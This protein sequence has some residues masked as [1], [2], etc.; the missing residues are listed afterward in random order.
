MFWI[1]QLLGWGGLGATQILIKST[2]I[3]DV[4]LYYVGFEGLMITVSGILFSSIM[5]QVFVKKV[6]LE[7]FSFSSLAW[8]LV[9]ILLAG[10]S[11]VGFQYVLASNVYEYIHQ[12]EIRYSAVANIINTFIMLILW[13]ILYFSIKAMLKSQKEKVERLRLQS[14]LKESQLNTLKGQIN[15]HFMFNSLNNIRGLMLEDVTKSREMIT[16]LS[17][18]LRYS[19]NSGKI[20]M[21]AVKEELVTVRNYIELS[22]IQLEDRLRYKEDIETGVQDIQIPPMLIQML[23]ENAI[24]HGISNQVSGGEVVLKLDI[25]DSILNIVVSNNGKLRNNS[26]STKI[27]IVNMRERLRLLYGSRASLE[28]KEV[29][30]NVIAK[31]K[32]PID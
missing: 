7:D 10:L 9:T 8:V 26:D 11:L 12:K 22:K 28:L 24:K 5:H 1:L 23:I 3:E 2:F 14:T 4:S 15:P 21:I 18:L 27:G 13:A 17:E 31:I 19:L 32:M 20:D 16:K 30:D 29:D 25:V 6:S